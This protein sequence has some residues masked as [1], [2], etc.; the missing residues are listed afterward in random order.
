MSEDRRILKSKK[1]LKESLIALMKQR[2]IKQITITSLAAHADVNRSTFYQHY[3]S[4]DDLFQ[5]LTEDVMEDLIRA[6]REPYI[7][8]DRIIFS[9]L[10]ATSIKIF[11]HIYSYADF[12]SVILDTAIFTG[13]QERICSLIKQL[14]LH[15][16]MEDSPQDIN[17]ELYASYH[18]HAITGLIVS[19][20]SEGFKFTPEYM[21]EQLIKILN[22]HPGSS[23]VRLEES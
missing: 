21:N 8:S 11:E 19:W 20:V 5:K 12:Y 13:F 16:L 2:S 17:A 22:F 7:G 10:S 6:Y 18:A 4:I 23:K 3:S 1:A 15:E 14:T 9:E